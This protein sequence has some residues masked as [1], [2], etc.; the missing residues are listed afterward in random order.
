MLRVG[1]FIYYIRISQNLLSPNSRINCCFFILNII[2]FKELLEGLTSQNTK[3]E[4]FGRSVTKNTNKGNIL[5]I[6]ID[7]QSECYPPKI[8]YGLVSNI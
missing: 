5:K 1:C 2:S 3:K 7:I 6:S 8:D 4:N